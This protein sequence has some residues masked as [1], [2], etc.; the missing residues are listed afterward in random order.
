MENPRKSVNKSKENPRKSVEMAP[1]NPWKSME[2]R[3]VEME[4]V[5]MRSAEN[6]L[7]RAPALATSHA[8]AT[9]S[10][11]HAV[12]PLGEATGKDPPPF[13]SRPL[14]GEWEANPHTV[15]TVRRGRLGSHP[16]PSLL[17]ARWRRRGSNTPL[18]V[19]RWRRL[20]STPP[21]CGRELDSEASPPPPPPR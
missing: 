16:P 21:A 5:E 9:R 2:M 10:W 19:D 11:F 15:L 17:P 1:Y 8:L 6:P 3:S 7:A 13:A 20:G 14:G 18:L 12:T 4:S